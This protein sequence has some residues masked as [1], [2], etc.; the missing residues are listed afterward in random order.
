ME[1]PVE[2]RLAGREAVDTYQKALPH[3]ERFAIM[4]ALQ[5]PPGTKGTDRAFMEGRLNGQQLDDMP[6]ESAKWMVKEARAAGINISGKYYCGGLA[7]KRAWKD[8]EA[9]ISSN[10]DILRVA[11]KRRMSVAG[12]VNYDPGPAPPQRKLINEKIV[13][14]E[15]AKELRSNPGAKAGEVRERILEKHTY[16]VKGR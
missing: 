7:D 11:K 10:D 15:V 1:I 9:W 3:G 16:R 6:T 4:V 13:K 12:S 8:P 2:V 14:R 5:S